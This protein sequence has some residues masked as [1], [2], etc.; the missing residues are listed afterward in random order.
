[1]ALAEDD[2]SPSALQHFNF[3]NTHN[4]ELSAYICQ[5]FQSFKYQS[6]F[7]NRL[8]NSAPPFVSKSKPTTIF[9]FSSSPLPINLYIYIYIYTP[10]HACVSIHK[11][12]ANRNRNA[13][14]LPT[15]SISLLRRVIIK[16]RSCFLI[17]IFRLCYD[18]SASCKFCCV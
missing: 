15:Q 18:F 14:A 5:D 9:R 8:S 6:S 2:K 13:R 7:Y 16:V 11:Q 4:L 10:R 1:M 17:L 3:S 12:H